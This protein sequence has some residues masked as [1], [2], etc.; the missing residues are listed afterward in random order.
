MLVN[1]IIAVSLMGMAVSIFDSKE[2]SRRFWGKYQRIK[3]VS[4]KGSWETI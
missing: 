2:R 3:G 4:C 1:E